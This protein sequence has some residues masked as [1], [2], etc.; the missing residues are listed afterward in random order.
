MARVNEGSHSLTCNPHVYPQVE[1]TIPAFA[2][3]PQSIT[4]LWLVLT[5]CPTEGRRL[6]W[7][8]RLSLICTDTVTVPV[9]MLSVGS[10]H[11]LCTAV[12]TSL[13]LSCYSHDQ[14]H[15]LA[16]QSSWFMWHASSGGVV[17]WQ[18]GERWVSTV[19][20]VTCDSFI[21]WSPISWQEVLPSNHLELTSAAVVCWSLHN[22]SCKQLHQL[23]E[24][25]QWTFTVNSGL[26]CHN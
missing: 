24:H 1:W 17:C 21:Y 9:K 18:T 15:W 23:S 11:S 3:Q 2:L 8:G 25:H 6:S 20:L 26:I 22:V 4:A 5:S 13:I 10:L 12:S 19:Y 7:P 14:S 16:A